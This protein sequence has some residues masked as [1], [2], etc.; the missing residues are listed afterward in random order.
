MLVCVGK[1]RPIQ[2][3]EELVIY[4]ERKRPSVSSWTGHRRLPTPC[5][6][7]QL[8]IMSTSRK[9]IESQTREA[10]NTLKTDSELFN[11]DPQAIA[12][13]VLI[14]LESFLDDTDSVVSDNESVDSVADRARRIPMTLEE[15]TLVVDTSIQR[16][17]QP[18]SAL[19]HQRKVASDEDDSEQAD[20]QED[21]DEEDSDEDAT[22]GQCLTPIA[23]FQRLLARKSKA[24]HRQQQENRHRFSRSRHQQKRLHSIWSSDFSPRSALSDHLATEPPLMTSRPELERQTLPRH[25]VEGRY[26]VSPPVT[27]A[28]DHQ[29][30]SSSKTKASSQQTMVINT[31]DQATHMDTPFHQSSPAKS[32]TISNQEA[33][34]QA[35]SVTTSAAVDIGIQL[36]PPVSARR[37]KSSSPV[38]SETEGRHIPQMSYC[39]E[40]REPPLRAQSLAASSCC[41]S[42]SSLSLSGIRSDPTHSR[43]SSTRSRRNNRHLS[44]RQSSKEAEM[45]SNKVTTSGVLLKDR[46]ITNLLLSLLK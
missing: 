38:L 8:C 33:A 37:V 5:L 16:H 4:V 11:E 26:V 46:D 30:C 24:F 44:R 2:V 13:R 10:N 45:R 14:D 31:K 36:S 34:K 17:R 23:G 32:E 27:T 21:S 35:A 22:K 28:C 18:I 19:N 6:C 9:P 42:S 41:S 3:T 29:C 1:S 43:V 25:Q 7:T 20:E 39:F 15:L 40:P 12:R